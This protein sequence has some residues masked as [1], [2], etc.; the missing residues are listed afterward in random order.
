MKIPHLFLTSLLFS[1][2]FGCEKA[3]PNFIPQRKDIVLTRAGE[4]IVDASYCFSF[5]LFKEAAKYSGYKNIIL[6][7]FSAQIANCMLANGADG[8]TYDQIVSATG[9]EGYS[10]EDINLAYKT[11]LKGLYG[12]DTSTKL[13]IANSIWIMRDFPVYNQFIKSV[14]DNY[15]GYVKQLD[16]SSKNALSDV[17]KWI[18]QKTAGH[19]SDIL[20]NLS[21]DSQVIVANALF[22]KG[23]WKEKFLPERTRTDF[24]KKA[25]GAVVSK[26]F[27][28]TSQ[29]LLYGET[30]DEKVR[31]CEIPYGNEA[32][33]LDI[34]LPVEGVNFKDFI[35]NLSGEEWWDMFT[36]K[37]THKVNLY[38]PKFKIESDLNLNS[39]LATLGMNLPYEHGNADFSRLS[40]MP[41]V[42]R[43]T[44]QKAIIDVDENGT[45]ATVTTHHKGDWNTLPGPGDVIE[46]KA[47]HPFVFLIRETT[48][49]TI[50][51]IGTLAE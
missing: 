26:R 43:E 38:L 44:R 30:E 36:Y 24:F 35:D 13:S 45:T 48:S 3:D 23:R 32:F 51:F 20:E 39:Q 47:D 21:P 28:C 41:L 42:I 2:L 18:S 27:M 50:L 9:F 1:L 17:N 40:N 14:E 15:D 25:D 16:F 31:L 34:I 8:D 7:P 22:F 46:F 12:V 5:N 49:K 37:S 29:D 10:L 4:E 33:V 11:V 19:I 6:S